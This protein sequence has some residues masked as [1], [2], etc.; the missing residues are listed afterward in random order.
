VGLG[1]GLVVAWLVVAA[2]GNEAGALIAASL[3][4]LA[5]G[6]AFLALAAVL[7]KNAEMAG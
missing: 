5:S 2:G 1:P 6:S 4:T 3:A 7:F